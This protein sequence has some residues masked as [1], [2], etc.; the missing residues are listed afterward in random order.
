[1]FFV[2]PPTPQPRSKWLRMN[3]RRH[4]RFFILTKKWNC[5]HVGV[6]ESNQPSSNK[7]SKRTGWHPSDTVLSL[8]SCVTPT[9]Q[10]PTHFHNTRDDTVWYIWTCVKWWWIES[11][12]QHL[13]HTHTRTHR[14]GAS[15]GEYSQ[16]NQHQSRE[17]FTHQWGGHWVGGDT[18]VSQIR[19]R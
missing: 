17:V 14:E 2:H 11:M 7:H 18:K 15:H 9:S 5:M 10:P 13:R 19:S 4:Q 1:M 16:R 12:I 6:C 3:I 8:Q